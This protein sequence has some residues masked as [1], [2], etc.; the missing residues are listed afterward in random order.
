M[1]ARDILDALDSEIARLQQVRNALA[2]LSAPKRR[3][4]P[5]AA[6]APVETVKGR[7]MS[8]AGRKRI[9][10]GQRKRWARQKAAVK[11]AARKTAAKKPSKKAA[12]RPLK[13]VK[14][15]KVPAKQQRE[16]KA[17]VAKRVPAKHALS[18][19]SEPV[20]APKTSPE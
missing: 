11:K 3:G 8:A 16:R 12:K 14:V 18:S 10:E 13:K 17:R 1:N 6:A 15:T 4:R 2:G 20:A 5:K 7:T 19:A 9:A